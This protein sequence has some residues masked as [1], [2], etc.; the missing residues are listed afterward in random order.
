MVCCV[1]ESTLLARNQQSGDL[2]IDEQFT[3]FEQKL[4][5]ISLQITKYAYLVTFLTI[6]S[7][8]V[9]TAVR[10]AI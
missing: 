3:Q 4:E 1:G 8:V 2:V 6:V 5:K 10:L 7:L 9:F